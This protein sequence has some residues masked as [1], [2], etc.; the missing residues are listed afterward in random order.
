MLI[1]LSSSNFKNVILS[2]LNVNSIRN[3]LEN[4]REINKQNVDVLAVAETKIDASIFPWGISYFLWTWYFSQE[5]WFV[6]LCK[7]NNTISS[8]FLIYFPI[9]NTNLTFWVESEKQKN[10]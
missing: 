5:R 7:S 2:Y 9:Q 8:T 6:S 3:K 1:F 10:D 4:L